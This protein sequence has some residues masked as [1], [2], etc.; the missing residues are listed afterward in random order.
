MVNLNNIDTKVCLQ[1]QMLDHRQTYKLK[2]CILFNNVG[3]CL[4]MN[5]SVGKKNQWLYSLI[6]FDVDVCQ[7]NNYGF[8]KQR[9]IKIW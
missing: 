9:D 1:I 8:K 5:L 2:L 4:K 7:N 6:S 3:K